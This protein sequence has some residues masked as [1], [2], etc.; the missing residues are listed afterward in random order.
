MTTQQH[1]ENNK[2][3][4]KNTMFLYFRMLLTMGVSLYTVRIVLDT[5]GTVDYGLYN[6]VGGVVTMFSF[7]SGTMSAA[8][9][10]FFAFE[11]GRK[12]YDQLKKTFSMT[13]IIY[14]M[15]AIVILILAE[16]VGLWFLY[17]KMTIPADRIDAAFWVYQF[18]ILSFMMTMFTIP[19]NALIIAHEKMNVYAYVS[20]VEVT[21][22]LIIVFLLVYFAFDKLILYAILIFGVTSF[23]TL[24]YRI[25]CIRKFKE[26]KFTFFWNKSLF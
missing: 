19:Y 22:K 14:V 26:A 5:L 2:R 24:I 13:M 9:Q 7:L 18:S 23:I 17:N 15:I 11:L 25:Y 8:S 16:T 3:I 4:A 6:V 1:S 20:I 10:R 21:L 12:N